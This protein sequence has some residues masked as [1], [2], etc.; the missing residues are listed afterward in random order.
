MAGRVACAR[1]SSPLGPA[2]LWNTLPPATRSFTMPAGEAVRGRRF[3]TRLWGVRYAS[4][5]AKRRPMSGRSN[6]EPARTYRVKNSPSVLGDVAMKRLLAGLTLVSV[7]FLVGCE[8]P[9]ATPKAGTSGGTA[10]KAP[11][12]P[13]ARE[14]QVAAIRRRSGKC[15]PWVAGI[16]RFARRTGI[17][18][19]LRLG[20]RHSIP[21]S[22]QTRMSVLLAIF[23]GS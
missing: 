13:A 2:A 17:H 3:A 5:A 18:A 20:M 16:V 15:P 11:A 1:R 4:A 12:T 23:L 22:R 7:F 21:T 14:G 6:H 9:K 19:C 10:A 8:E